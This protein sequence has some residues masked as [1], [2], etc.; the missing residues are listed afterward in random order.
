MYY[1]MLV[2]GLWVDITNEYIN[3]LGYVG[4]QQLL[5]S[6]PSGKYYGIEGDEGIRT[7]LSFVNDKFDVI[8]LFVVDNC[9]LDVDVEN[10]IKMLET[11]V[12]IDDVS[13]DCTSDGT[14]NDS[15]TSNDNSD[16][17]SE[18]L[19]VLALER[20]RVIDGSLCDYKDLHK[21]MTYKDIAEARRYISLHSL[22]NGCN[23]TT[24]KSDRKRLR[25]VCRD[26]CNF[27]CL[28]SG[29]K[30]VA[31]V[32]VKTLKGEHNKACKDPCGNYKVS[33]TTMA[34]YFKEKLQANPKYKIK[35]MRVDMKT[36]FNINAH[37]EKCKRA[38]R[39][40]LEDMEGSFCDDYKKIVGYA[41]ALKKS[42]LSEEAKDHLLHFPIQ[43]WC[44][45]F[46]DT[47]CKNS[48]VENNL[49]ESFN[50]W[51][52][53]ARHKL[54]IGMLEDI[55]IN[56]MT[57][58][59]KNENELMTWNCDWSPIA[60]EMYN[61]FLKIANVCELNFNGDDGF[62]V[63]EGN[64][65]HIVNLATKKCTCRVWDLTGIPC[66]HSIKALLYKSLDPLEEIHWWYSKEAYLLTYHYKL[67]PVPGQKFWKIEA[68]Q[69][70]E[71]PELVNLAGK[72]RMNRKRDKDE[73]LKR[74]TEWVAPRRRRKITCSNC[75]ILGHNARGCHKFNQNSEEGTSNTGQVKSKKKKM[76]KQCDKGKK[77]TNER[78]K[79]QSTKDC[80]SDEDEDEDFDLDV[81]DDMPWKPRDFSA[82]GPTWKGNAPETENMLEQLRKEKMDMRSNK[83]KKQGKE[84]HR[85]LIDEGD[86]EDFP[87]T[88]PQ[89]TQDEDEDFDLDVED[90]MS[91]KPRDFSELNSR[92]QQRQNQARPTRSRRIN[93]LGDGPSVP[94]DLYGP[95]GLT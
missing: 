12:V 71:P 16:Y 18:E 35:E 69:A 74:Q 26:K 52:L 79:T 28:I 15:D 95:K 22:A 6:V 5:V 88:A 48:K 82:K 90:D 30:H 60:I 64:D 80:T 72:P 61:E 56:V 46:F 8:N 47:V 62:E 49:V 17:N 84:R 91:W 89:P 2:R 41:N 38:K 68:E 63:S 73:A 31:G 25:V 20:R 29:E 76:D 87:L 27:V 75:G 7:L 24:K 4:V 54:I 1:D 83:E 40:I 42:Q 55:R 33:A 59:V 44:R 11:M 13:T 66:P 10:I 34:F 94:S 43:T 57:K 14:E 36:A 93:F 70:I 3:I 45:V 39:M 53:E 51:L 21:S 65:R 77:Q 58:F 9:E 86:V 67:Q 19:E 23:L 92:I 50:S 32:R 81:E 37:F 78:H 85:T